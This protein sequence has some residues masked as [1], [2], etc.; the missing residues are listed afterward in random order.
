MRNFDDK[1]YYFHKKAKK[2]AFR[3][4]FCNLDSQ[5]KDFVQDPTN[6]Y[7]E[8]EGFYRDFCETVDWFF[9]DSEAQTKNEQRE[10]E[11]FESPVHTVS[12]D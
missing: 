8:D 5:I 9:N 10:K 1:W 6:D 11:A 3:Q 2:I 7:T 4:I 12:F